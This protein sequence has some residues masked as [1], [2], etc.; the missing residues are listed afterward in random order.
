MNVAF[1]DITLV[2]VVAAVLGIIARYLRQPTI[3]AY[4]ITGI[5]IAAFGTMAEDS[6]H[7]LDVMA[8]FGTTLLLFLIGLEMRFDYIKTIGRSALLTAIGQ[9]V[10]TSIVGF[11]IVRLLGFDIVRSL[12]IAFA[13]TFSSTIVVVKLL[14]EK[15]ELQSLYGRIVVGFLI[16]QDIVAIFVMIFLGSLHGG[17][18]SSHIV[19]ISGTLIKGILLLAIVYF[20]SRKVFPWIFDKL[21]TSPEL[22]FIT[23]IAWAFGLSALVSTKFIGL[24]TEIGGFLAGLALA[25]SIEQFQIESKLRPL[26]DFFL[27]IFFVVLGFSVAISDLQSIIF[28]SI[29]LSLFVLIGNPLIFIVLMGLLGFRKKT[30]FYASISIAQVSEFSLILMAI[31]LTLGHVTKQ[32]VSL[33]TSIGLVTFIAS[34]YFIAHSHGLFQRFKKYLHIFEKSNAHEDLPFP[35]NPRGQIL[36]AG[37]HRLGQHILHCINK[38]KLVIVE[39]DPLIAQQ[40]KRERYKVVFGDITDSDIQQLVHL[41]DTPI[42][43]STVPDLDDSFALLNTIQQMRKKNNRAPIA[44][45]TAYSNWEARR[46][47]DKGA[48]YVILPHFLGGKHVASLIKDGEVD[49]TTMKNW[50]KHDFKMLFHAPRELS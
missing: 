31:G 5:L 35:T 4:L 18:A 34:A 47:Y 19:A 50:R 12:Y 1:F 32:D 48:N 43:I 25:H 23:S 27:V 7:T 6:R 15:R 2:V 38:E 45:M 11:G 20:L 21:A 30:S 17:G 16:I 29:V 41:D 22:L 37:A 8:T 10:I 40:L 44:I 33:V 26:R 9:I 28:P 46:L 24:S 36:L 42:L 39:F 3:V 14:S 49:V 13:L